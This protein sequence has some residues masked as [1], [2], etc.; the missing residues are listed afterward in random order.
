WL[1]VTET[2][3]SAAAAKQQVGY[4]SE[5]ALFQDLDWLRTIGAKGFFVRGFQVIP[6]GAT[7]F[8]LLQKPEQLDWIK[9]YCDRV[10]REANVA[11]SQPRT[12]PFPESA[13]GIVQAGPIGS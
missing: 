7:A 6:A 1:I 2:Y 12:L 11:V 5:L 9:R 10:G 8:Q 13:A 4:A 3:D